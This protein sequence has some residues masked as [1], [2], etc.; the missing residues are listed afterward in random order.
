[1]SILLYVDFR[2]IHVGTLCRNK[3]LFP[4]VMGFELHNPE[5]L[6]FFKPCGFL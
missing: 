3:N 5:K 1:M 4:E 2:G 6:V